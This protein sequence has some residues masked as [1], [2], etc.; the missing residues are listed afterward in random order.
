MAEEIQDDQAKTTRR[1]VDWSGLADV[2]QVVA[3][4]AAL[5]AI[6]F[7]AIQVV[8]L[9]KAFDRNDRQNNIAAWSAVVQQEF[10]MDD[11]FIEYPQLQKYFFE[12]VPIDKS[13]P[14]YSRVNA[15][16]IE[17]LDFFENVE[18]MINYVPPD[19]TTVP[20]RTIGSRESGMFDRPTWERYIIGT[21]R[22]SP[23]LCSAAKENEASYDEGLNSLAR[24]GCG[25]HSVPARETNAG[26]GVVRP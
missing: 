8:A 17:T 12:G 20:G 3:A 16:A 15:I 10:A 6:L 24:K 7:T 9:R 14:D 22:S 2:A 25:P 1:R 11:R 19:R 18:D 21:F 5:I 13:A 4:F 23:V 26:L